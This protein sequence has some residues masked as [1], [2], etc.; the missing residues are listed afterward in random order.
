VNFSRW[1]RMRGQTWIVAIALLGA[2]CSQV[3]NDDE[4]EIRVR[5]MS[6]VDFDSVLVRFPKDTHRYGRVEAGTSSPYAEVQEAYRYDYVEVWITGRKHVLQP[7]DF[8][9]ESLLEPGR[10]TY[11]LTFE[12]SPPTL[13]FIMA[14]DPRVR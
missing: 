11:G 7:I 10:H 4:V 3:L 6:A 1:N 2:G 14:D 9:G 12:G 8:V 13:G 5:N